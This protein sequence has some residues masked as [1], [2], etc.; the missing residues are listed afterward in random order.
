MP[1]QLGFQFNPGTST[2][3]PP[4]LSELK[5]PQTIAL[6]TETTGLNV[7]DTDSPIG[8]SVAGEGIKPTYIPIDTNALAW[9]NAQLKG[10][11]ILMFNAKFDTHV[12]RRAGVDFESLGCRV[13]DVAFAAAL[14]DERRK[15]YSLNA[16]SRDWLDMQKLE[17]PPGKVS[18]LPV[19]VIAP[20]AEQDANL[21]WL[22][23]KKLYTPIKSQG[24]QRVLDLEDDLIYCTC[25]MER[26]G[27]RLD[28]D[29]LQKWVSV[30][31]QR[32][33]FI[34]MEI[35]R[36]VGFKVIPT[37]PTDLGRLFNY[38]KIPYE[39]TP[40]GL[41]SFT[42]ESLRADAK[43]SNVVQLALEGRQLSY[44]LSKYLDKY[45][46][47]RHGDIMRYQLHQ[48]KLD[49]FGTISGRYSSA[50]VNIQQV[51]NEENQLGILKEFPVREL[52]VPEKGKMWITADA[53]QIEFRI[54]AHYANDDYV[55]AAYQKDPHVDF[56]QLVADITGLSRTSSKHINF[57]KLYGMGIN[58]LIDQVRLRWV[59]D[60]I[61]SE[62]QIENMNDH[63]ERMF[64]A[65]KRLLNYAGS[66]AR[67]RGFVKT[68]YGRTRHFNVNDEKERWHSALNAVIQG[69]A[70]DIMK[71]KLL[72]VYRERK[73]LGL[74]LRFTVHDELDGDIEDE[75]GALRLQEL[76]DEQAL[77]LRVPILWNVK[78]GTSWRTK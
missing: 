59:G 24:L 54:F 34:V 38:L 35:Y 12:M 8:L 63:Y 16:L 57:G 2:W 39:E 20:Y 7:I 9:C 32:F 61:P 72:S 14:L 1:T 22:L 43:K 71:L 53:S 56:H 36:L 5:L 64:P 44:L 52:F 50:S 62:A 67:E 26:N 11:E 55:T 27:A 76:L 42:W 75:T 10:K 3:I 33:T 15:E 69:T 30:C 78:T 58:K 68:F 66:L 65:V 19:N 45:D 28:V 74:T 18:D 40:K 25:E 17:L 48:L 29:K 47:A 77:D 21:T 60:Q 73:T 4:D 13:R 37:S 31:R 46:N 70:A 23:A 51:F 41:P 49:Q 6:D